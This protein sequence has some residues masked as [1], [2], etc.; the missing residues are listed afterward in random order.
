MAQ[1]WDLPSAGLWI[2]TA[3]IRYFKGQCEATEQITKTESCPFTSLV[4]VH[5]I[6][7]AKVKRLFDPRAQKLE[8]PIAWLM[9]VNADVLYPPGNYLRACF[10]LGKTE[11]CLPQMASLYGG[12]KLV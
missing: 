2:A 4:F 6:G 12:F 10:L 8:N 11:M 7:K 5:R 3:K 1:P 9:L